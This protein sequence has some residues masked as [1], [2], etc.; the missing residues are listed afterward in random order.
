MSLFCKH[1]YKSEKAEYAHDE[2]IND[3]SI[4]VPSMH[5]TR[6]HVY[7]I[8]MRCLKCN[9]IKKEVFKQEYWGDT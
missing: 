1:I 4:I 9:R 3:G 5:N 2:I 8:T 7:V 6:Y